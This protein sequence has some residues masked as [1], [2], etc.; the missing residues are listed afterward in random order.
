MAEGLRLARA[1][2][3]HQP[4]AAARALEE[5]AS[6]EAA[7]FLAELPARLAAP[8]VERLAPAAAARRL[9][10]LPAADAAA[11]LRELDER[12]CAAI[13]RVCGRDDRR[14][15]LAELP[16]RRVQHYRRASEYTVDTVGAWVDYDVPALPGTRSV[17]EALELLRQRRRA[18]DAQVFVLRGAAQYGG[19][20]SVTALLHAAPDAL[21]AQVAD[22]GVR[23]LSDAMEIDEAEALDDWDRATVLPVTAPDGALLGGLSRLGL[24]RALDAVYPQLP[25]AQPDSLLAHLFTAYLRSGTELLRLLIGHAGDARARDRDER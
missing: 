9:C 17:A 21:L 8:L 11:V 14:A 15:L 5:I 1:F 16:A 18:Q 20:V 2:A 25:P 19:Q 24:R 22:R 6:D 23:A 13:L 12:S 3:E 10:A 7:L 4:D